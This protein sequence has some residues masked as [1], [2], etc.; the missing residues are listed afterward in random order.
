MTPNY[1]N[2]LVLKFLCIFFSFQE[3]VCP[4]NYFSQQNTILQRWWHITSVIMIHKIVM[5][6]LLEDPPPCWFW[7]SLTEEAY[8]AKNGG[9]P[10]N[11]Q[12]ETKALNVSIYMDLHH[13]NNQM[14]LEMNPSPVKSWEDSFGWNLFLIEK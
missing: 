10:V 5:S 9:W 1:P 11:S 4:L 3:W 2:L 7:W 13:A 14:S 12:Q 8:M 6:I